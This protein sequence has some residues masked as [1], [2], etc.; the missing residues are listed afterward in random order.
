MLRPAARRR[1]LIRYGFFAAVACGAMGFS[2]AAYATGILKPFEL[3]AIDALFTIRGGQQSPRE[4]V[5]VKID[6][7]TLR[8]LGLVGGRPGR[9]G[10]R[11]VGPLSESLFA[12]G[13]LSFAEI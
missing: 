4:V 9:G 12:R 2:L 11:Q 13:L 1:S 5:L 10:A 3:Y 8:R 6:E 7:R